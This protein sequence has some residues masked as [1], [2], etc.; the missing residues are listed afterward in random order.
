MP[1]VIFRVKDGS[2]PYVLPPIRYPDGKF[3]LKIGGEPDAKNLHS[4][5]D[6]INWFR[7]SGDANIKSYMCNRLKD[8]I[9]NLTYIKAHTKSCVVTYT[10]TGL[11]FI[12]PLSDHLFVAAGG[13]GAAAKSSDEIGRIAA[14]TVLGHTDHR[15]SINRKK[16][17]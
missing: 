1:S 11:P 8:L 16:E 15:F 5:E 12:A 3:Y 4:K 14:Q 6:L 9:P 17:A 7:S 2:D 13:C 10:S